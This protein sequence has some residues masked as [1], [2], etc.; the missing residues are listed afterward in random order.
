MGEGVRAGPIPSGTVVPSSPSLLP[1]T[2]ASQRRP[3]TRH[4]FAAFC[5]IGLRVCVLRKPQPA[6]PSRDTTGTRCSMRKHLLPLALH[7][8]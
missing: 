2:C 3:L 6:R 8:P 1:P 7:R 5:P 4:R